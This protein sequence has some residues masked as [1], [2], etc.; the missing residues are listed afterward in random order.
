MDEVTTDMSNK[1]KRQSPRIK[2]IILCY[3]VKGGGLDIRI[4]PVVTSSFEFFLCLPQ[5]SWDSVS[6]CIQ[7]LSSPDKVFHFPGSS[8]KSPNNAAPHTSERQTI[9]FDKETDIYES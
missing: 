9:N 4:S 8:I 6:G 5:H 2:L 7:V 3:T 1:P